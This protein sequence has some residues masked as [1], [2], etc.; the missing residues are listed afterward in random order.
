MK[1]KVWGILF[2]LVVLLNV[3][4]W[5]SSSF[6]N[7]YLEHI[8][9]V[10]GSGFSRIT[11]VFAFSVGEVM[12]VAGVVFVLAFFAVCALRLAVRREWSVRL[13][14]IF[15]GAFSWVL[16]ALFAV[17]TCNC[18][19]QYH[20]SEF[21]E[22]FM[23]QVRTGGYTKEELGA[24]RDF[25][26]V[27]LN[28]LAEEMV[29]DENG[30]L[31]YEGDLHQTAIEAM[32]HLG[33]RYDQLQGFYPQPKEMYFSNLISQ[34]YMMGYYFPFSMEA[35]YNG[36]MYV[37]NKPSTICHELAH[38]KGFIQ[39]DEASLI[40]YLACI[41][42]EDDFFRYSGYMGVLSYVER[43]FQ[44]SI[45]KNAEEY[46]RHPAIS[47][48]VYKD[49]VFLTEEAW[50][51]V[52]E[53]AVVSTQTAKKVSRAATT[54]SLKLNSNGLSF[55]AFLT[56]SKAAGTSLNVISNMFSY[57]SLRHSIAATSGSAARV[58]T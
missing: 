1:K 25:I 9:P 52:E 38:L 34:T 35:N 30:Y 33:E 42:S 21:E 18:F 39:E 48:Q 45:N 47:A 29:R 57:S 8:F 56:S 24:L 13:F 32:Q 2:M 54:A 31:V 36:T 19:I 50:Q 51:K 44:S 7:F 40:G 12:I 26:V 28:D 16:L 53:K 22:K 37:V 58:L 4:A 17:L 43:E 41:A 49:S 23:E 20:A 55:A 46:G 5:C 15:A 14:R 10:L 6:C 27:N 11:S 3:A